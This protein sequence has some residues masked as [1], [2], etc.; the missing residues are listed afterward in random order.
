M[1]AHVEFRKDE[2]EVEETD[3]TIIYES[4]LVAWSKDIAILNLS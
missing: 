1:L 2:K 4:V 3:T